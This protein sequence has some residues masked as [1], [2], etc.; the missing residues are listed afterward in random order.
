MGGRFARAQDGD[1]DK[2]HLGVNINCC[3]TELPKTSQLARYL[4][5][6]VIPVN[7]DDF[8]AKNYCNKRC[9]QFKT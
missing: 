1:V 5:C 4:K 3:P 6:G 9:I 7:S 2:V 8:N